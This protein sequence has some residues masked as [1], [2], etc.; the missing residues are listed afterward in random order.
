MTMDERHALYKARGI[1]DKFRDSNKPIMATYDIDDIYVIQTLLHMIEKRDKDIEHLINGMREYERR[2]GIPGK[3][4]DEEYLKHDECR[5]CGKH[6]AVYCKTCFDELE[7]CK[8]RAE[9][10]VKS[11]EEREQAILD[12]LG[13]D[14]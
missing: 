5:L 10:D 11:Y 3:Y 14:W 9:K 13:V 1:I 2:L 8:N 6:P 4:E 7:K 12:V